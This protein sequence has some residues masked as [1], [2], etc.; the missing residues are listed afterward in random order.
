[1]CSI[2]KGFWAIASRPA[3][4]GCFGLVEHCL[5]IEQDRVFSESP[6]VTMERLLK[7]EHIMGIE[8]RELMSFIDK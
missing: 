8:V 5:Q 1:M 4:Y 2:K 7:L 6:Q 3:S